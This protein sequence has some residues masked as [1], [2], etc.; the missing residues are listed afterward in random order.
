MHLRTEDRLCEHTARRQL[1]YKPG[2]EPSLE[3]ELWQNFDLDCS[4]ARTEKNKFMLFKPSS[5]WWFLWAVWADL[6]YDVQQK[7]KMEISF[8]VTRECNYFWYLRKK[9]RCI[10]CR[11]PLCFYSYCVSIITFWQFEHLKCLILTL[12]L[13][14]GS[15]FSRRIKTSWVV[16]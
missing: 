16:K 10:V 6:R 4:A 5:L 15:T 14:F 1:A 9:I 8:K 11:K 3:T 12:L 13:S 2:K 7:F